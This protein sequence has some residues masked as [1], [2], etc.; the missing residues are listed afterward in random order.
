MK[1]QQP[2]NKNVPSIECGGEPLKKVFG[3]ENIICLGKE[4]ASLQFPGRP[5]DNVLVRES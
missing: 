2:N 3:I 4:T 5:A 1:S